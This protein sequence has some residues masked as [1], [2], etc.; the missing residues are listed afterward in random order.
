MPIIRVSP[1]GDG[2]LPPPEVPF[3]QEVPNPSE[4]RTLQEVPI[5]QEVPI[6]QEVPN[7]SGAHIAPGEAMDLTIRA[8]EAQYKPRGEN[9]WMELRKMSNIRVGTR[10]P[11]AGHRGDENPGSLG[12]DGMEHV[13]E[14]RG[15][16]LN[17]TGNTLGMS[18]SQTNMGTSRYVEGRGPQENL[19]QPLAPSKQRPVTFSSQQSVTPVSQSQRPVTPSNLNPSAAYD[20]SLPAGSMLQPTQPNVTHGKQYAYAS[21]PCPTHNLSFSSKSRE[22]FALTINK[23]N[24]RLQGSPRIFRPPPRIVSVTGVGGPSQV[25]LYNNCFRPHRLTPHTPS[26]SQITS[27]HRALSPRMAQASPKVTISFCICVHCPLVRGKP[28]MIWE[29]EQ[30]KAKKKK[31]KLR[32]FSR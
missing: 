31:K 28:L 10:L 9:P 14:R 17:S 3:P 23:G 7:P 22:S 11:A 30:R 6:T 21:P 8:R 4:A 29:G 24:L 15:V 32:P 25:S 1:P 13:Q 27:P 26:T 16:Q 19:I 18:T 2:T 5:P 20:N 12:H